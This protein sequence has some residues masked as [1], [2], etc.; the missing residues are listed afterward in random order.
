ME[1]VEGACDSSFQMNITRLEAKLLAA[2]RAKRT[3]FPVEW[4]TST[5]NQH[6]LFILN[7]VG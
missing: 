1:G 6:V 4:T 3:R 7:L 5:I 2:L